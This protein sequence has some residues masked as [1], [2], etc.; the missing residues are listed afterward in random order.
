MK[1]HNTY[2]EL[3]LF[4]TPSFSNLLPPGD[5]EISLYNID[6]NIDI[7]ETAYNIY[8]FY[9]FQVNEITLP[10]FKKPLSLSP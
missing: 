9:K 8:C 7:F 3:S 1:S 2:S 6:L 4:R 10:G 5:K